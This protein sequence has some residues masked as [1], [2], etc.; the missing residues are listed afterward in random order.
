M[1]DDNL[2]VVSAGTGG[3]GIG[4]A[5]GRL[6]DGPRDGKEEG[7]MGRFTGTSA[8]GAGGTVEKLGLSFRN[9]TACGGGVSRE[10]IKPI[11]SMAP[12][13]MSVRSLIV[14][15]DEEP[16][17]G[18]DFRGRSLPRLVSRSSWEKGV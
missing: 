2:R 12:P 8:T 17:S 4:M 11:A 6:S 1:P 13:S 14:A 5:E 9:S 7:V 16:E 10:S 18:D 3:G 15:D